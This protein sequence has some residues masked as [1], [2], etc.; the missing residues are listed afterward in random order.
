[1]ENLFYKNYLNLIT[2][3]VGTQMFRNF[4]AEVE[5]STRDVLEDGQLS[6]ASFVSSILVLKGLISGPHAMVVSTIKGMEAAGWVKISELKPG[7]ILL[8]EKSLIGSHSNNHIGFYIGDEKAVSNSSEE[9]S[10]IIHHWTYGEENG[11]P[12]RKVEAI[13]WHSKLD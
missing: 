1:M 3:S 13:Y 11:K 12:K 4:W 9:R 5:G 10:P 8:W 6:C 7:A 2:N